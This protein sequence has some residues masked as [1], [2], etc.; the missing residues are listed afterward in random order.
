M[1]RLQFFKKNFNIGQ[2][3]KQ[4]TNEE[5]QFRYQK[6]PDLNK[7]IVSQSTYFDRKLEEMEKQD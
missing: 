2:S 4:H 7:T 6:I 1:Y 3:Y 5:R